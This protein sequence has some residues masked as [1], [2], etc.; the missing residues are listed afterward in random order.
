MLDKRVKMLLRGCSA[1]MVVLLVVGAAAVANGAAA[2]AEA[3]QTRAAPV[4]VSIEAIAGDD[5]STFLSVLAYFG[6]PV[7]AT[8]NKSMKLAVADDKLACKPIA[9]VSGIAPI[10]P[11]ACIVPDP[12]DSE[13]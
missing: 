13:M 10:A 7:A 8:G 11:Q 5:T 1:A 4:G 2:E 6:A 9:Q 12:R 3:C